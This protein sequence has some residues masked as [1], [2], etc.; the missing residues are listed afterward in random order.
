[1]LTFSSL[2]ELS[3]SRHHK[4]LSSHLPALCGHQSWHHYSL[5]IIEWY[6]TI[7]K[8]AVFVKTESVTAPAVSSCVPAGRLRAAHETCLLY[9]RQVAGISRMVSGGPMAGICPPEDE[10]GVLSL[11]WLWWSFTAMK[12]W[13]CQDLSADTEGAG[14]S[15]SQAIHDHNGWCLGVDRPQLCQSSRIPTRAWVVVIVCDLAGGDWE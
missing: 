4:P 11:S 15:C 3:C 2:K 7:S 6:T 9:T 13:L 1:M 12:T 10:W 8:T 14:K 5:I